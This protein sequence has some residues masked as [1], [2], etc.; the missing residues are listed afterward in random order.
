MVAGCDEGT[1]MTRRR[2]TWNDLS[3][4]RKGMVVVALPLLALLAD[5]TLLL[6]VTRGQQSANEDVRQSIEVRTATRDLVSILVDAETG[7]R[8]YLATG[9]ERFLDPYNA[10]LSRLSS[11]QKRGA[12]LAT[13]RSV[14]GRLKAIGTLTQ[15]ELAELADLRGST[16]MTRATLTDRLAQQKATMDELRVQTDDVAKAETVSLDRRLDD[17]QRLGELALLTVAAGL[18]IGLLGGGAAMALF[19]AGVVRRVTVLRENA[20]RLEQ[21]F[22]QLDPPAG[23]D[24][25]GMLGRALARAGALLEARAEDALAAS[26]MKSEFLANMSHEIRT[27][28][29]GVLGMTQL[30]VGTPLDDEQREYADAAYRSAESL[31]TVINDILDFSKIEA[32]RMDF[33]VIDF[34][35]RDVVE[36]VAELLADRAHEKGLELAT[37]IDSDVPVHMSGDPG[38]IRQV[39]LNLLGNAVKFTDRGEVVMSVRVEQADSDTARLRVEVRDTGIG[40]PMDAQHGLFTS[41]VQADATTTRTHGGT[42]LGLAIAKQLVE[43]MGGAIGLHSRVGEGSTFWFTVPFAAAPSVPR[44]ASPDTSLEGLRVLV[45]DD[46]ATNRS[47]LEHLLGRWGVEVRSASSAASALALLE[48]DST[49]FDFAILDYHM[50]ITDGLEL[51]ASISDR[52]LLEPRSLV[53]LTSSGLGEDRRRSKAAGLGGYLTKP[54]R[55][56]AL[57]D[58][59]ADLLGAGEPATPAAP[60]LVPRPSI[61]AT[62]HI[63]VVEDNE[64]NQQVARRMLERNG[65]RVDIAGDGQAAIEAVRRGAYDVILM[66]CQMPV[67]DGFGATRAIRQLEGPQQRTPII[68]MTAGAM[69]GDAE[70]CLAA[71][72]DDYIAK[73][74][75]WADLTNRIDTLLDSNHDRGA[76]RRASAA[77]ALDAVLDHAIVAGLQELDDEGGDVSS[78]V[79]IFIAT[80]TER[81][82]NLRDA[83]ASGDA[84]AGSAIVHSLRG[85]TSTLGAAGVASLCAEWE[86]TNAPGGRRP[87]AVLLA[88]IEREFEVACVAL[89]RAFPPTSV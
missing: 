42:G 44:R 7:V 22:E 50:P 85:S 67:L 26:R 55:Q 27:P 18:L 23:E 10:A 30:L 86:S 8:G 14:R 43:L 89:T 12:G 64:V 46:N 66:D 31:L 80:G 56:S 51:A 1:S 58:C 70:A 47:I 88:E 4:R 62:G 69:L 61:G 19:T 68:A 17:A 78:L 33:E 39:L 35:V 79:E 48:T 74:V 41:F 81:I 60:Q 2:R 40:I 65:H 82:R 73:P 71:G 13:A 87:D 21:G 9:D 53:L 77:E 52:G 3:I 72:M 24:E 28:M 83:V 57:Y 20:T 45:V 16:G 15:S 36:E 6:L 25:V 32:G 54:V 29:N 76:S 11:L 49:P 75:D 63:L 38:R 5:S 37:S 59:L 34:D 84:A